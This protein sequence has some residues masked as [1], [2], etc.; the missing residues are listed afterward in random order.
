MVDGRGRGRGGGAWKDTRSPRCSVRLAFFQPRDLFWIV[1][2]AV[3]FSQESVVSLSHHG[4]KR[5]ADVG[6]CDKPAGL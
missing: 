6:D 3:I 2:D 5:V 1:V 4:H